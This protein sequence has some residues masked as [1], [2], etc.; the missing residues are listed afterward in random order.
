MCGIVGYIG[1]DNA[2][3]ILIDGLKRLEYRGYDS[4][5]IATLNIKNGSCQTLVR[6]S[7]GKLENL[8]NFLK[9][10]PCRGTVGIG[11]TRWAT[12]GKPS[13]E[14]AHPHSCNRI[15]V[16]H[17]GIIEN[18]HE[19]LEELLAQKRKILSQTDTEIIAHLIAL[20]KSKG[21]NLKKAMQNAL[22]KIKGAFALAVLDENEPNHI[23]CAKEG[24]PLIIGEGDDAMFVASDFPALLPYTNKFLVLKDG[25]IAD[26]SKQSIN[27]FDKKGTKKKRETKVIS[28]SAK[29]IE[30]GEYKHFLHKEIHEQPKAIADTI[31]GRLKFKGQNIWLEGIDTQKL[32]AINRVLIVAC[33]TSFHSAMIGKQIIEEKAKIPVEIELASEF[34]YRNCILDKN[35]LVIGISQSGETADTIGALN[36]A[37]SRG[38][39]LLAICNAIDSAIARL[40]EDDAGIFYTRAGPEIS[41]ASTK[42]FTTQVA[43]LHLLALT[44][45]YLNKS[46]HKGEILK[47]IEKLKTI[48]KVIESVLACEKDIAKVAQNVA[49]A[50]HMLFLGRGILYPIALEGA[51]KMKEISYLHAEGY[52]AGEMKHGPIALIDENM[53]VVVLAAKGQ[54]YEKIVSNLEEVKAR[55]GR[56]LVLCDKNDKKL[57]KRSDMNFLLPFCDSTI[58]PFVAAI[59]LQLF[60]YHVALIRGTDV[61]QPRNLAKSVTVE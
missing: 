15:S 27:I 7:F 61:D 54:G 50:D 48:P 31:L 43:A 20:E 5:G 38:M 55:N 46:L 39:A 33:G 44:F 35:T 59:P 4:A 16:V 2:Q 41:V 14:N 11:H 25:D 10:S 47:E 30:K 56:V 52:A 29:M 32:K 3:S 8:C 26:I 57:I 34:R 17:N 22:L 19:I 12:H 51:L 24:S 53:P 49:S 40:C 58:L 6:K 21:N 36:S 18:Y 60:A 28:Y 23:L 45:A 42:A 37:K 9:K 1:N 13:T